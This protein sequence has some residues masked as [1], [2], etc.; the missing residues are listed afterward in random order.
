MNYEELLKDML[1]D[2]TFIND[3][4]NYFN[5]RKEVNSTIGKVNTT[6]NNITYPL[7]VNVLMIHGATIAFDFMS[8]YWQV[9]QFDMQNFGSKNQITKS[10]VIT[11][12][13]AITSCMRTYLGF[14]EY[15]YAFNPIVYREIQIKRN[16]FNKSNDLLLN[17]L[18]FEKR[19]EL[20]Q[21][22]YKCDYIGFTLEYLYHEYLD[23]TDWYS[24]FYRTRKSFN[25]KFH[26]NLISETKSKENYYAQL[27]GSSPNSLSF[28][29][30]RISK[31]SY[32]HF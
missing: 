24:F 1:N 13:Q 30:N 5:N 6:I 7:K 10:H 31:F 32:S 17:Q 14:L 18:T 28:L 16:F 23:F 27:N 19:E 25:N 11:F 8:Y 20:V 4:F 26:L 22:F 12:G 29:K 15:S 3:D 9:I 2:I 21:N